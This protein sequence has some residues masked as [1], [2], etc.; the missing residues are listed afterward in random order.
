MRKLV[1]LTPRTLVT[2]PDIEQRLEV[3]HRQGYDVVDEETVN[4]LRAMAAPIL[5]ADGHP[6]AAVS[7]TAPSVRG[8]LK[9][10]AKSAKE[11]LLHAATE[12]G[13]LMSVSG[14]TVIVGG[15]LISNKGGTES[16]G[17]Y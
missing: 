5:D 16:N 1:R 7:V 11:P 6:H 12:L 15:D 8:N 2:I 4:G 14:A 13:R 17:N 9:D 3:V 10:F